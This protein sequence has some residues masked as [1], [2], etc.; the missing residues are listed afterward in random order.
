VIT[1]TAAEMTNLIVMV[2]SIVV[3]VIVKYVYDYFQNKE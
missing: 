2:V 1:F 3:P